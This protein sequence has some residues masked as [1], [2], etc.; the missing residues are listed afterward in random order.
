MEHDRVVSCDLRTPLQDFFWTGGENLN[1]SA[2]SPLVSDVRGHRRILE[3]FLRAIETNGK[4]R[5]DGR[6][7]RRSVELVQAIYESS[8]TGRAVPLVT[9]KESA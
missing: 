9:A 4:P 5:C 7:A 8:R 3:D 1:P 2:T 6:E